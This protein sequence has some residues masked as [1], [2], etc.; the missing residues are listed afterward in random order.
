V[1]ARGE[2][3][4]FDAAQKSWLNQ[5]LPTLY[6]RATFAG[7]LTQ[8]PEPDMLPYQDI[9]FQLLDLPPVSPEHPVPWPGSTLQASD[10]A[11]LVVD[12]REPS[13]VGELQAVRSILR[14][15]RVTL[16]ERWPGSDATTGREATS[17]G[18]AAQAD[19]PFA[20]T[21]PNLPK[22]VVANK[23]EDVADLEAEMQ[24][25]RDLTDS[26]FATLAVSAATGFDL[27]RIAP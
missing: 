2:Q 19:D 17:P 7:V 15:M 8:L 4:R 12:L 21:L 10:A 20:V 13:C 16:A 5:T 1:N 23:A 27:G 26:A 18:D 3:V 24:A 14:A 9:Q 22:P 11:L 6:P 25:L